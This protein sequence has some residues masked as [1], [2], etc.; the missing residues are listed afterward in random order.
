LLRAEQERDA[1]GAV[2]RLSVRSAQSKQPRKR[3]A[4]RLSEAQI[5]E[6]IASFQQGTTVQTLAGQYGGSA[7]AIKRL[8]RQRGVRANR[9]LEDRLSD[10]EVAALVAAASAGK[11]QRELAKQYGISQTSVK[12]VLKLNK[13]GSARNDF[14]A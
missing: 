5:R 2:R 8:L 13:L 4:D 11:T 10:R 12:K 6:L 3:I 9:T 1:A 14:V 7:T